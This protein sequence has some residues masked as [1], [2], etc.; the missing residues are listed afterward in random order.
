[1]YTVGDYTSGNQQYYTATGN[2]PNGT[3]ST[4]NHTANNSFIVPVDEA[5]LTAPARESPQ[6][7]IPVC[8]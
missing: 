2:Y 8:Q 1:M 6:T 7:I 4:T 5:L 3:T